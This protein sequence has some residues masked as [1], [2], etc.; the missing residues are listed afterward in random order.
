MGAPL[1][2]LPAPAAAP[3]AAAPFGRH[4]T[5]NV[6]IVTIDGVR[7]QEVFGGVDEQLAH[8]A[9]MSKCEVLAGGEL[10][11]NLHRHFVDRGVVIG[12]PGYG[13]MEASG[14]NFVSL[15]GYEEI[16]TGRTST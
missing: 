12:A 14:P 2:R 10:M 4:E 15:P 5:R 1:S 6:I 8:S 3:P 9:G 16:F 7:W 11:P 13:Q